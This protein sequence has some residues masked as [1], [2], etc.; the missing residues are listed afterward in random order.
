MIENAKDRLKNCITLDNGSTLSLFSNPDLV[1]D[2]Q[3]SSKALSL[4]TNAGVLNRAIAKR[5]CQALE[6]S[7][8]MKRRSSTSLDFQI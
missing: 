2:I 4:T 5:T 3:T 7:T 8:T 1:Q 6:K